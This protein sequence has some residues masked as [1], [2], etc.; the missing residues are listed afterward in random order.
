[1]ILPP[2]LEKP[3]LEQWPSVDLISDLLLH[4]LVYRVF[5]SP[6]LE[7]SSHFRNSPNSNLPKVF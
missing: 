4:D 7:R 1:M 5:S 6:T 3:D 2:E